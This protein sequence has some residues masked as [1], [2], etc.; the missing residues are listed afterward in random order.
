MQLRRLTASIPKDKVYLAFSG[1]VDSCGVLSFLLQSKR[2]VTLLYFNHSTSTSDNHQLLVKQ[3]ASRFNLELFT[4]KCEPVSSNQNKEAYWREQR[5]AFLDTFK[6]APIITCH[7]LDDQVENY[8]F[9][10]FHGGTPRT[11]QS[12]RG[13]YIRPFLLFEKKDLERFAYKL[14]KKEE[15]ASDQTNFDPEFCS[16]NRIRNIVVPEVLKINPGF[17]KQVAKEF[18]QYERKR[19]C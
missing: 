4:S 8:L 19:N 13:N 14:F 3:I 16:R 5:Y 9:G 7:H 17:K 6:D 1:G 18:V 12:K 11:I 15:I 2:K 10:T